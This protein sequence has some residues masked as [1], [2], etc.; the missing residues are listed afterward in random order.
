MEDKT[1]FDLFLSVQALGL[2]YSAACNLQHS[3]SIQV[4][5]S[6]FTGCI[7]FSSPD[8]IS[9]EAVMKMTYLRLAPSET[10]PQW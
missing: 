10:S 5:N 6:N 8:L 3:T 4:G 7:L 2:P 9:D 1:V